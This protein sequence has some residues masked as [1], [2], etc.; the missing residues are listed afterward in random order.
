MFYSQFIL[1]KKGPLGTIWIAAHL[2]RKLRKNQVADTDIGVSVD[3]ILCPDVP[4]A[5]RLSSHLLLGVVR[6]YSRKVNYLFDDCSEALLKI[7]QAFRSTAVDLPPEESTA[8]YHSITL[9]ETFDLDDFELPDNDIFQGLELY[10]DKVAAAGHAGVMMRSEADPQSSVRPMT[11]LKQ[12]ENHEINA[13]DG[14]VDVIEYAQAPRTPGLLEEPNLSNVQETSA[15]DDQMELENHNCTEFAVEE[16]LENASNKSDLHHGNKNVVDATLRDHTNPDDVLHMPAGENGYH[17]GE[18]EFKQLDLPAQFP[19]TT[20]MN[21]LMTLGRDSAVLQYSVV[22]DQVR[23][24][25][26][27]PEMPD[28]INSLGM[29]ESSQNGAAGSKRFGIHS[30]DGGLEDPLKPQEV[31]LGKNTRD[32]TSL[33]GTCQPVEDGVSETPD[34]AEVSKNTESARGPENTCSPSSALDSNAKC[35]DGANLEKPDTQA[36]QDAKDFHIVN[37]PAREEMAFSN[38]HVLQPCSTRSNQLTTLDPG[39]EKDADPKPMQYSGKDEA[40][41]ASVAFPVVQGERCN[42]TD[43]SH[44]ILEENHIM[45]PASHENIEAAYSKPDDQ[46]DNVIPV[47]SQMGKLNWASMDLPTPEKLLCA[48]GGLV[49]VPNNLLLEATPHKGVLAVGDGDGAGSKFFSGK[50]RSFNDSEMTVQSL[51]SVA[52][53][54]VRGTIRTAEPIPDDNDLLSSILVGRRSSVLKVKPTPPSE[55]ISMKRPRCGPRTSASK[56]KVLMDDT[57]VLHGDIIRQQ[58]MDTQDIRRVRKKA[59]C[60]R[61]EISMIQK[62]FLEEEIFSDPILT[63]VSTCLA[64][65]H[66]QTYDLGEIRVSQNDATGESFE[67]TTNLKL[68][69][70]NSNEADEMDISSAPN[71]TKELGIKGNDD[72]LVARDYGAKEPAETSLYEDHAAAFEAYAAQGQMLTSDA[73]ESTSSQHELLRP[74][75]DIIPDGEKALDADAANL[76]DPGEE[77]MYRTDPVSGDTCVISAGLSQLAS[78]DETSEADACPQPDASVVASGQKLE[79]LPVEMDASMMDINISKGDTNDAEKNRD[80]VAAVETETTAKDEFLLE[81]TENS[82]SVKIKMDIPQDF[83]TQ[84]D[85][86]NLSA[87]FSPETGMCTQVVAITSE[88]GLGVVNEVVPLDAETGNIG[89]NLVPSGICDGEFPHPVEFNADLAT[90]CYDDGEYT[91]EQEGSQLSV[92]DAKISAIDRDDHQ[93]FDYSA[94]GHDT[95]FLNVDDEDEGTEADVDCIPSADETRLLDNSGWSSRTR[96]V[97]KYLQTLFDKEAERGRKKVLPMDN[98]LASKTRKEASR[99]FFEALVLKT[100]DYIHVEQ[101]NP[102][103]NIKLTPQVKLM[104]SDF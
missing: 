37:P 52:T 35:N 90:V 95:E 11:P 71:V 2:E 89:Q 48:P 104:K 82:A 30:D 73:A 55:M 20:V 24:I 77:S 80:D 13:V 61:P 72:P 15:C 33:N 38:S 7:K 93:N 98:L 14:D 67:A 43:G 16:S 40:S 1:A 9:P 44:E 64:S 19:S 62:Q 85:A 76:V 70:Q 17:S 28:K 78:L 79:M 29:M 21:E 91:R 103:D 84:N 34:A 88:N 51:N 86:T 41:H 54:S 63:G 36:F 26:P 60:T 58:L 68:I 97:A 4:I 99:M 18:S 8:P 66:N 94:V 25:S 101:G 3:S 102:F 75:V 27:I 45:E 53:S 59:P 22:A 74:R 10:L 31:S 12:D 56:R 96:A 32:I 47:E 23:A 57:M 92:M 50:K 42:A 5:L 100:K 49:D 81:E 83:P 87:T 39:G 6:I 65:L 46:L 69:L